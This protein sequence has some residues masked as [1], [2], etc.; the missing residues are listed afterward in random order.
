[1]DENL[2]SA[3]FDDASR[4]LDKLWSAVDGIG[5]IAI[6][7]DSVAGAIFSSKNIDYLLGILREREIT[8][9]KFGMAHLVPISEVNGFMN[10]PA[11]WLANHYGVSVS[12]A[13]LFISLTEDKELG[14]KGSVKLE[15]NHPGC[16]QFK[17]VTFS[18]PASMVATKRAVHGELWYCKKH[19]QAAWDNERAIAS[20]LKDVLM[21]LLSNPALSLLQLG[22][23]GADA[24][25][26][27]GAGLVRQV[28]L[29]RGNSGMVQYE[30]YL[31]EDGYAYINLWPSESHSLRD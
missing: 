16:G 19:R 25:F 24:D 15:C 20:Y 12:D 4:A 1:M 14:S 5:G 8:F 11:E 9:H 3:L 29:P 21:A 22:V 31:T 17:A 23:S 18:D 13:E 2:L 7:E 28:V 6:G 30:H 27:V 26:L 10:A